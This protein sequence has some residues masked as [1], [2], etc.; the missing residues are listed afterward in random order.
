[1]ELGFINCTVLQGGHISCNGTLYE[2]PEANLTADDQQFWIYVLIYATLILFAGLMSGLTLG[3]LSLDLE[4]LKEL[5]YNGTPSEKRNA[6]K[7]LPLVKRH[8]LLLITL[9]LSNASAVEA[10][11]IFLDHISTPV[12][13]VFVSVTAVIVCGE[14]VPQAIC[15]RY[16][17]PIWAFFSPLVYFLMCALF[18][19]AWPIS[20]ILDC[21]L[22]EGHTALY[23]R[24]PVQGALDQDKKAAQDLYTPSEHVLMLDIEARLDAKTMNEIIYQSQASIPIYEGSKDNVVALLAVNSLLGLNTAKPTPLRMLVENGTAKPIQ[25]TD[26]NKTK[27]NLYNEFKEDSCMLR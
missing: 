22:G 23:R 19:I 8:H 13:A 27:H 26:K 7:V 11:P 14:V 3:L 12:I 25:K 6:R 16:G 18:V 2:I 4:T 10:M 5:K 24:A 21:L 1:M 20:K 9:L 15:A 17:L